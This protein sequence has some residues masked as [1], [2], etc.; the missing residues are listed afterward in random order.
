MR[1]ISKA[2]IALIFLLAWPLEA[3]AVCTCPNGATCNIQGADADWTGT[4]GGGGACTDGL[5]AADD[6]VGG[7]GSTVSMNASVTINTIDMLTGSTFAC[8]NDTAARVLTIDN[9]KSAAPGPGNV[10][11]W[12]RA[13][14]TMDCDGA[15]GVEGNDLTIT[16]SG[17]VPAGVAGAPRFIAGDGPFSTF[18]L[19][20]DAI[21]KQRGLRKLVG[22]V[23]NVAAGATDDFVWCAD[24]TGT[25]VNTIAIGDSAVFS[26]GR[27]DEYW[28]RVDS[29]PDSCTG[30]GAPDASCTAADATAECSAVACGGG[31]CDVQIDMNDADRAFRSF[32]KVATL[33]GPVRAATPDDTNADGTADNDTM[34]PVDGD[35]VDIF[36]PTVIQGGANAITNGISIYPTGAQANVRYINFRGLT[37]GE[38]SRTCTSV[39]PETSSSLHLSVVTSIA[40]E[41]DLA[42][43][44]WYDHA[45]IPLTEFNA[46]DRTEDSRPNYPVILRH[47]YIHD[48]D[49]NIPGTCTDPGQRV[50]GG[51]VVTTDNIDDTYRIDGYTLD[52]FHFARIN[53]EVM[54]NSGPQFTTTS[55][56]NRITMT[57]WV[58]HDVPFS[59]T[60]GTTQ[61]GIFIWTHGANS[62]LLGWQSWDTGS[63]SAG[64][65]VIA[66]QP[67]AAGITAPTKTRLRIQ[68]AY[69]VN[70]D[71]NLDGGVGGVNLT[72]SLSGA[73]INR[74]TDH[75][76]VSN[77]YIGHGTGFGGQGGDWYY[78]FFL[79]TALDNDGAAPCANVRRGALFFPASAV[80]NVMINT[81][82]V[83]CWQ[84]G[85]FNDAGV[86]GQPSSFSLRARKYT[87]N[88]IANPGAQASNFC[89]GIYTRNG[90]VTEATNVDAYNNLID[91]NQVDCGDEVGILFEH[92]AGS[93]RMT[94]RYN[95]VMNSRN[96]AMNGNSAGTFDV[97]TNRYY[98]IAASPAVFGGNGPGDV[99]SDINDITADLAGGYY[100]QLCSASLRKANP[101]GGPVGPLAFGI[102]DFGYFHPAV[103]AAM[104]VRVYKMHY[105]H[106]MCSAAN[107][108]AIPR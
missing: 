11:F 45:S 80:G 101:W 104:D 79:N 65:V 87:S 21:W 59:T 57:N 3:L 85:I 63:A 28:G 13:G 40:P 72:L 107:Q 66:V 22:S 32:V 12:L 55:Q 83:A 97:G 27:L 37:G 52:G 24:L 15:T 98:R 84:N 78:T 25:V 35:A 6:V 64:P 30:A 56:Y 9:N 71:R 7:T 105:N 31:P 69:I 75:L 36:K 68:N 53:T 18:N 95:V 58:V 16:Y 99:D 8:V 92:A 67:Y 2:G 108:D 76:R 94:A 62:S 70:Y 42:F 43:W 74:D 54:N 34:F 44:N 20:T 93:L 89:G 106:L 103:R 50:G 1:T 47:W 96:Q 51:L 86:T 61:A 73:T 19:T 29:R 81:S 14:A 39:S 48:A 41:G 5:T 10:F 46:T 60:Y 4:D 38:S 26:S 23:T 88:V 100:D 17:T 82:P 77:S 102:R 90:G 33:G 91:I 49:A